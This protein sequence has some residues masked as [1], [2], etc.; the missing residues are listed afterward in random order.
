MNQSKI[1]K[2]KRIL[3]YLYGEKFYK[4]LNYNWSKYPSRFEIIQKIIDLKK[5]DKY[6]EIGCDQDS[7]FSRI[8][9]KNKTGVDP[10]SG[11]SLRMTSDAFFEKNNEKY[12]CIFLDGLHTYEQ[13]RKDIFNSIKIL[14]SNGIIILHDCLPSKIWN[15]IVPR[16]YGHWNGDV[17]KAIVETRT[18]NDVDTYT[19]IADHGLGMILKRPNRNLLKLNKN[20]FKKLK[21]KDYYN[22]HKSFMNLIEVSEIDQ[23]LQ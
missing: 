20:N 3:Y 16:I 17:W 13:T 19:C 12:N 4:R 8:K 1:Y 18:L 5:Y 7:N 2:L 14:D 9:V 21:F 11:G 23:I 10:V 22:N 6:L 15:Q